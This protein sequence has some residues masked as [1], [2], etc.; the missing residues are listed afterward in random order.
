MAETTKSKSSSPGLVR[1]NGSNPFSLDVIRA[2]QAEHFPE[3]GSET[4]SSRER[5]I[6]QQARAEVLALA[7]TR[8]K[9]QFAAREIVTL[10]E[11]AHQYFFSCMAAIERQERQY[12]ER[13]GDEKFQALGTMFAFE[14]VKRMGGAI[15]GVVD[16]VETQMRDIV[17]QSYELDQPHMSLIA[18]LFSGRS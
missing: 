9:G 2:R 7:L 11:F 14:G 12:R 17:E 8:R 5:K 16:A 1:M 6:Y 18:R 3:I 13:S 15:A 4:L 10:E